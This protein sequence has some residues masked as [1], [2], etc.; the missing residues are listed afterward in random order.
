MTTGAHSSSVPGAD[1]QEALA[2][3]R[4]E[5]A[6]VIE[7]VRSIRKP[8]AHAIGN[9]TVAELAM[10]LTQGWIIVPGMARR[11]LSPVFQVL[12]ELAGRHGESVIGD[13]WELAGVTAAGVEAD[14][15]RDPQVLADRI[16][17][18]A[19]AYLEEAAGHT[20]EGR[21]A[22]LVEGTSLPMA[23]FT[24]HLLNEAIM[25]GGDIA[26]AEGRPWPVKPA[27]AALVF[28]G[29]IL[30]VFA[31]VDPRSMV[32]PANAAGLK[33]TFDLRMR[34]GRS[35]YFTFDDGTLTIE[36]PSSRRVDC[37]IS[38]D[39]AAL[40]MVAWARQSQ[41]HAIARGKLVAWGRKPWLGLR[42]RSLMRNP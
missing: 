40:L 23:T 8:D 24:C 14:P 21:R 4:E 15:E 18:R 17:A 12:P 13:V 41:W 38:A 28:D 1:P 5:V 7:L 36:L 3:L 22:W 39:P 31:A 26:R 34:G 20:A 19:A 37:H 2:A 42:F 11:D 33:A 9:W 25:H 16:E 30:P 10:H 6:R 27:H 35:Y 32:D 29:F